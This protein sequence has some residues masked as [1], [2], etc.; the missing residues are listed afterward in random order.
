MVAMPFTSE[1]NLPM[2]QKTSVDVRN[3]LVPF[4]HEISAPGSQARLSNFSFPIFGKLRNVTTQY[5]VDQA[6]ERLSA[7]KQ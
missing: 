5:I 2:K 1:Q 6:L 3:L 7:K 4:G